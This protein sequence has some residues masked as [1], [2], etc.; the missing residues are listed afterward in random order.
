MLNIPSES[1]RC[2]FRDIHVW[3][4]LDPH[5]CYIINEMWESFQIILKLFALSFVW[6]FLIHSITLHCWVLHHRTVKSMLIANK[7]TRELNFL[8]YTWIDLFAVWGCMLQSLQ[9]LVFFDYR[10]I[11]GD[12]TSIMHFKFSIS[13]M[14]PVDW[15]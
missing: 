11:S 14:F 10:S 1:F 3:P 13:T 9:W 12:D 4:R 15:I 5:P 7:P 8:N 6:N 2:I